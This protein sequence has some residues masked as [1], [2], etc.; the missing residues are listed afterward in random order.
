MAFAVGRAAC[1][2]FVVAALGVALP[3]AAQ[4]KIGGGRLVANVAGGVVYT[5]NYYYQPGTSAAPTRSA[6]GFV[7]RPQVVYTTQT[8]KVSFNLGVNADYGVWTAPGSK[9]DYLDRTFGLTLGWTPTFRNRFTLAAEAKHGHDPFGQTRTDSCVPATSC[10][11]GGTVNFDLDQWDRNGGS[12][13]Y[14]YGA[15]SARLNAEVGAGVTTQ[16]Y[17]TNE[18]VAPLADGTLQG[19]RFLD[20]KVTSADYTVLYNYTPKSALVL[21]FVRSDVA[22]DHA[23]DNNHNG[24]EDAGDVD[25]RSGQLYQVRAGIRWLATAK[26]SGDIRAG[27][28]QRT[29][30]NSPQTLEGFDWQAGVQWSPT[31]P[32]TAE[33]RTERSEEPSY[34]EDQGTANSNVID[35]KAWQLSLTR[36]ANSRTNV[37]LTVSDAHLNFFGTG[38]NDQDRSAGL[39]LEYRAFSYMYFVSNL[40][41]DERASTEAGHDYKRLGAFVG[42]RLGRAPR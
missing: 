11:A 6:T 32:F 33:L 23:F 21:N 27:Y 41:Y 18:S 20:Y 5:D 12:V 25:T 22:F 29:F 9:D 30:D 36:T 31:P 34:R 4:D 38:R 24:A 2:T 15:P 1:A 16:R 26:T 39:N 17:T 40:S 13:H 7:V 3:A 8:S 37:S 28:R 19:T 35:S 10:P 14:R 42:L